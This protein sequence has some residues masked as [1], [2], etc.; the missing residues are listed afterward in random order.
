MG[1][2]VC[3]LERSGDRD[4]STPDALNPCRHRDGN[5]KQGT[6]GLVS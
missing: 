1:V 3:P 5:V 4:S 2:P 6:I